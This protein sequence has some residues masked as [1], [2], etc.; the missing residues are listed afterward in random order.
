MIFLENKE[1]CSGCFACYSICPKECI[2]MKA[3]CEG[4]IYPNID[5]N[6]CVQCGLCEKICPILTPIKE[7]KVEQKGY[8]V[9][10]KEDWPEIRMGERNLSKYKYIVN[11]YR[12]IILFNR[13][14]SVNYYFNFELK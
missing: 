13:T 1:E 8:L 7:E 5:K 3:D 12:N 6:K 4:F 9:Q 11:Y 2:E 10:H 14:S